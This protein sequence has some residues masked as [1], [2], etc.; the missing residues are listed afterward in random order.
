VTPLVLTVL[1]A[2]NGRVDTGDTGGASLELHGVVTCADPSARDELAF[3]RVVPGDWASLEE[4]SDHMPQPNQLSGGGVGVADLDGDGLLDVYVPIWGQDRL[5]MGVAGD[6]LDFIDE[7]SE[8]LPPEDDAGAGVA[9]ADS[10]GDGDLDLFISQVYGP[11]RLLVNDG[12][13]V[14]TDGTA[15]AGVAGEAWDSTTASWGDL[16]GD[17]DLDLFVGAHNDTEELGAAIL[18]EADFPPAHPNRLYRNDGGVFDDRTAALPSGDLE[19]YTFVA[20]WLDGDLD[21]DQDLYVV[22]DFGSS[23]VPNQ[24]FENDGAG[25][26]TDVTAATGTGAAHF[27]MGLGRG[28]VNGDGLDDLLVTGWDEIAL[29]FSDGPLQWHDVTVARGL[30]VGTA[31]RHV[32]WGADLIDVDNDGDLDA[33]VA[34]GFLIMSDE[35]LAATEAAGHQDPREQPNGLWLQ[36][37]HGDFEQA[38][39]ALGLDHDGVDRGFVWADLDGDGALDQVLRDLAGPPVILKGTCTDAA[40]ISVSVQPDV[41]GVRVE[42]SSEGFSASRTVVAG[43]VLQSSYRGP[44]H[45]GLGDAESVRLEVKWPDGALATFDNVPTRQR[46]TVR[47]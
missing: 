24:F 22:N 29:L 1:L 31:D 28:D 10:D 32:S 14:F 7:T 18:G 33:S 36:D 39:E 37:D 13:G 9:I 40:W 15:A 2:C 30:D 20:G 41:P 19:P 5:L 25:A 42:A 34:F 26:F 44:L 38:A 47:R 3:E 4:T 23:V 45:L 16:D 21:G 43:S 11:D 8:R 27:G 6:R 17:G 12:D 35:G 46:V